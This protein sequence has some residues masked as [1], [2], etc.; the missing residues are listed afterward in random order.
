MTRHLWVLRWPFTLEVSYA[1][2]MS[3]EKETIQKGQNKLDH[4]PSHGSQRSTNHYLL[5][6]SSCHMLCFSSL[7]S[8]TQDHIALLSHH[9]S[10]WGKQ[11]NQTCVSHLLLSDFQWKIN[12][13]Q[14]AQKSAFYFCHKTISSF[15]V[16]L[17]SALSLNGLLF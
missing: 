14:P 15:F 9:W 7:H 11:A 3:S 8:P 10:I 4:A 17:M 6:L 13:C 5:G 12:I 1:S 16:K 2:N